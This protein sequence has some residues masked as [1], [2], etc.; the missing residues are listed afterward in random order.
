MLL[1]L[2]E[3]EISK[4]EGQVPYTFFYCVSDAF[5]D[6]S[7]KDVVVK[8]FSATSTSQGVVLSES[9]WFLCGVFGAVCSWFAVGFIVLGEITGIC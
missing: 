5:C 7:C 8:L 4:E 3:K 2:R 1:A 9:F 6:L